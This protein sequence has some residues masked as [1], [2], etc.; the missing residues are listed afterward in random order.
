MMAALEPWPG[1]QARGFG[2]PERWWAGVGSVHQAGRWAHHEMTMMETQETGIEDQVA[3]ATRIYL[4]SFK[5]KK[6]VS[7]MCF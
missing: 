7:A 3:A 2:L 1:S 6:L 4:Y 5:T